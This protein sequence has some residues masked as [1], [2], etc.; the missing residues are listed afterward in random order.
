M[1][2]TLGRVR[3]RKFTPPPWYKGAGGGGMMDG[4]PPLSFWYVQ[5]VFR[6]YFILIRKPLIF[7]IRWVYFMGGSVAGGLWRHQ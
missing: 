6:N 5:A 3:T 1:N 7:L 4:T 2:L